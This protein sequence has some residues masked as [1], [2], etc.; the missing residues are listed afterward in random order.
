ML[1]SLFLLVALLVVV[2][3]AQVQQCTSITNC[4]TCLDAV[5]PSGDACRWCE[6]RCVLQGTPCSTG[7]QCPS[8]SGGG[9]GGGNGL[10]AGGAAG[11]AIAVF[12]CCVCC[13]FCI[14]VVA[15]IAVCMVL[16]RRRS[17]GGGGGSV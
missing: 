8:G 13:C 2:A 15:A 5:D 7:S 14:G 16:E 1:R 17:P 11:V 10:S 3:T 4:N 9:G 6:G 12:V